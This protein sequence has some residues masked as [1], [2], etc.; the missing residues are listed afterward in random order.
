[1]DRQSGVYVIPCNDCD[2]PYIGYKNKGLPIRITEHKRSVRYGHESSAT[3]VHVR[4]EN[5]NINW[6]AS[7]IIYGSTCRY[8]NKTLEFALINS[9]RNMNLHLGSW[10]PDPIDAVILKR[11]LRRINCPFLYNP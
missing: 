10:K 3:F 11:L 2:K 7:E 1:M 9:A 8:R 6:N 4:N 5:H